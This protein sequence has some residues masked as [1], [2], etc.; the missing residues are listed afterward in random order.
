MHF[1]LN[2]DLCLFSINS[3]NIKRKKIIGVNMKLEITSCGSGYYLEHQLGRKIGGYFIISDELGEKPPLDN[4]RA[5][6]SWYSDENE[7]LGT[8][9]IEKLTKLS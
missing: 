5:I 9:D 2:Y 7:F 6:M 3:Q 8:I 1:G 4:K